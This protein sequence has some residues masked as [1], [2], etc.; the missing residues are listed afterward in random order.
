MNLG[1]LLILAGIVLVALGVLVL[2]MNRL[3]WP[4][5][6][7]PGD[8]VWRG[9]QTTVYIPWVSCLLLSLLGSLVL[10]LLSRRP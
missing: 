8:I 4:L 5:G 10:W 7:L 1:R 2:I 3:N 6:R 9:K